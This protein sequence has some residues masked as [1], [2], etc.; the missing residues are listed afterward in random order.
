MA[1]WFRLDQR[2]TFSFNMHKIDDQ[3]VNLDVFL[4]NGDLAFILLHSVCMLEF[5]YGMMGWRKFDLQLQINRKSSILFFC[6]CFS[7]LVCHSISFKQKNEYFINI[8]FVW[9]YTTL[10]MLSHQKQIC[11]IILLFI[12]GSFICLVGFSLDFFHFVNDLFLC[13]L[14]L[15]FL[16][17]CIYIYE[18]TILNFFLVCF[19]FYIIWGYSQIIFFSKT[20]IL[21]FWYIIILLYI[22]SLFHSSFMIIY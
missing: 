13:F 12:V 3:N 6:C 11:D 2:E 8:S 9:N 21:L 14:F 20:T 15:C 7:F 1:S 10:R 5:H 4:R 18:F 22:Y 17:S 19:Y 16:Q